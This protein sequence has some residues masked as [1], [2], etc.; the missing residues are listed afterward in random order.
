MRSPMSVV[1]RPEDSAVPIEF[2]LE[3]LVE[4]RTGER[5][6]PEDRLE[7]PGITRA[8]GAL[9]E[10][11]RARAGAVLV[12][13][14]S[15]HGKTTVLRW[16]WHD[17]PTGF[18]SIVVPS[19]EVEPN[20]IAVRILA[21]TRS[22][23]VHDAAAALA[24][25]MRAQALRGARPVLVVDDLEKMQPAA[26]ARLL[27]IAADSRVPF[28]VLAAGSE[29]KT[30]EALVRDLPRPVRRIAID[31]P[32]SHARLRRS[33]PPRMRMKMEPVIPPPQQPHHAPLQAPS[34]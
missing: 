1:P 5:L 4:A 27:A 2:G 25:L 15:G 31:E 30:L 22:G 28:G 13:G 7:T 26:L 29:G 3:A 23:A 20:Q 19:P 32:W 24:R 6:G 21:T 11:L 18:A 16:F 8:R 10:A 34:Q 14:P 17:P 9:E 33:N 12:T